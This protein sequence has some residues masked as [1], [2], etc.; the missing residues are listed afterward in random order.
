MRRTLSFLIAAAL[1]L[2]VVTAWAQQ[3]TRVPV[4]GLLM[5]VAGVNDSAV[6]ALREGLRGLGYVEGRNFRFEHR[7]AEGHPERLAGLAEELV[8]I[9]VD[10]I[11]TGTDAATRAAKQASTTI[12][13]VVVLPEDDPVAAGF[14]ESFNH[15]GSNITGLT[16]RN[17]Q[18]VG[19][20]LELL[21]EILPGLSQVAVFS[22]PLVRGEVEQIRPA[23][24]ALGVEIQF[25]EM[26]APYDFDTAFG[27]AQRQKAGAVMLLSSP[28]VYAR[29]LQL[30]ALALKHRLPV[31]SPFHELTR[32]G[33]LMS[34]ST[35]V[36]DG[37]FRSAYYVDQLL[38]GAK[39]SDLPFEQTDNI[40]FIVNLK[41][42]DAL[43]IKL[44]QSIL[45]RVD[46]VIK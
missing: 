16:V 25:V 2:L 40:K 27:R 41:T 42:A 15:P 6:E 32:A 13:I 44:P 35:G 3:P 7:N 23:A 8:R 36:K 37:F 33:G 20:R 4:V 18:L 46:E 34:Y 14:I 11:V 39:A 31:E 1:G 30:G 29:R 45:L 19:K 5:V 24:R 43:G 9:R 10:V 21:K 17:S 38:K 12:P 28:Q 26:N 22:D